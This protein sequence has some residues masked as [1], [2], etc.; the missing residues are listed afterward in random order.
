MNPLYIIG[1]DRTDTIYR[2][3][4]IWI[5]DLLFPRRCP[6]CGE[7]LGDNGSLI[8]RGCVPK[9]SPVR[10]PVCKTCG[11][12]LISDREEYCTDCR[13]HQHSF[14]MGR[15]L[16]QYN[17][18][19]A[20]SMAAIKYK[21]R[22]E[23]L[24]FY[25]QAMAYRYRDQV[26]R[27]QPDVMIPI[28]VHPSRYRSRGFNQAEELARR[29]TRLW[30]IPTETGLLLR[31]KRTVAQKK[32]TPEERLKNLQKAF[33]AADKKHRLPRT[34]LL[35]DDIYTTGSTMEACSRVLLAAGVEKVYFLTICIG[36]GK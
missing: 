9:L 31:K 32:L 8:C 16:F 11:K 30:G 23:Y 34:V 25:A 7:I 27:W 28:P 19:A 4:L 3:I 14:A 26:S 13:R 1:R 15:S 17:A 35:I 18:A 24:D 36:Y 21:N 29:L 6:V 20:K 12:E 10:Q 2:K 5:A 33:A 22:R